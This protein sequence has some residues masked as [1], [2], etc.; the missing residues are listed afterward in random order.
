MFSSP[1]PLFNRPSIQLGTL[2]AYVKRKMPELDVTAHHFFLLLAKGLGYPIYQEISQHTWLAESIYASLLFPEQKIIAESLFKQKARSISTL[3][4]IAFQNLI[5]ITTSVTDE[6]VQSL[7]DH[8]P[9]LAGFSISLC[10]LTASLYLIKK[11]K[12]RFPQLPVVVG[13]ALVAGKAGE[14]LKSVFPQIDFVIQGEG[15]VPLVQLVK[16]IYEKNIMAEQNSFQSESISTKNTEWK[17]I[18]PSQIK[19]LDELPIPDYDDYFALLQQFPANRRFFPV[20]SIE[21]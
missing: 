10:Q 19:H 1:W 16:S 12:A 2:K 14:D 7:P 21:A 17:K 6:F 9:L 18:T 15:E 3:R 20:L 8:R 4:K 5:A 11:I 13:G